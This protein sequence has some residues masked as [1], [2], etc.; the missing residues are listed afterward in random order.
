MPEPF[1]ISA[2]TP[3]DAIPILTFWN[4]LIENTVITF[5]SKLK[6]VSDVTGMIRDQVF[7]VA[8]L[9]GKVLGFA[10]Y[11]QFRNGDGYARTMEH[12]I[13]LAQQA[14]SKGIGRALLD[15]L[16]NHARD[17]G[18]HSFIAGISGQNPAAIAFHKAME[19]VE[20]AR[21]PQAGNKFNQWLDLVLMQK[22]L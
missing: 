15:T 7:I 3:S 2:A 8:K 13:I 4:P 22:I 11:N 14:Q 21:I 1:R 16:E 9:D 19:Y 18:C 6:T 20:V 12:T 17:N 10:T 5:S